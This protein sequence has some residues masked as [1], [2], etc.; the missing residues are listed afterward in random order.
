[1]KKS[2][3][4]MIKTRDKRKF[5]TEKKNLPFLIE[6]AKTFGAELSIITTE[7][8]KP[9]PLE[10]LAAAFCDASYNAEIPYEHVSRVYPKIESDRQRSDLID[11]ANKIRKFIHTKLTSHKTITLKELKK[12]FGDYNLTDSCLCNH[13]TQVRKE[14]ENEGYTICKLGAGKYVAKIK[15]E[16]PKNDI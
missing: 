14:V 9:T 5:F 3:L 8:S 13:L 15:E 10:K 12:K 2:K 6:F 16:L 11:N 7:L 1:M 4:L